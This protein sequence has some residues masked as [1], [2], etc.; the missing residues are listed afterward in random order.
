MR[1]PVAREGS[2]VSNNESIS[3]TRS[4][5][6]VLL[7]VIEELMYDIYN[8]WQ[9]DTLSN[10]YPSDREEYSYHN[11]DIAK[12]CILEDVC[13]AVGKESWI[14]GNEDKPRAC[15]FPSVY[16]IAHEEF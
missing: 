8:I 16:S 4:F 15:I 11:D 7:V 9:K 14:D 1:I 10:V 3:K 2:F 6:N 13:A 5:E 12:Y